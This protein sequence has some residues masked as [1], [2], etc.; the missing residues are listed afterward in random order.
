MQMMAGV[1]LGF[2]SCHHVTMSHFPQKLALHGM[3]QLHSQM[4]RIQE[5]KGR[6]HLKINGI[7]SWLSNWMGFEDSSVLLICGS[8]ELPAD[9]EVEA[10][11]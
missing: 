3:R 5:E 6:V 10:W 2:Q 8:Q 1:P 9:G 11:L 4:G 7:L